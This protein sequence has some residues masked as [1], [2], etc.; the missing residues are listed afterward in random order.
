MNDPN[1][2]TRWKGLYHLFY[3]HNPYSAEWGQIHWGHAVSD[4][5]VHWRDLPIA[6][7]PNPKGPDYAGCWSGC[8]V[9]H[10]DV[11]MFFYT[12]VYPEAVCI[13]IGKDD[14]LT[15]DKYDGNPVIPAPPEGIYA[16]DP[17][18]FRDPFVWQ[19]DDEWYMLIASRQEGS[20]G[21]ALLYRSLDLHQWEYLHPFFE[22][23][24]QQTQ[25]FWMG[26]QW[27]C[28]NY[29]AQEDR[30]VLIVSVAGEGDGDLRYPAYFVGDL[31]DHRLRPRQSGIVDYGSCFY[32][33]Q[34]LHDKDRYLMWGWLQE[35]RS[36]VAQ[37]AAGWSGVMSLPR[38]ISLQDDDSLSIT[39]APELQQLRSNG[40]SLNN[41]SLEESEHHIISEIEGD[42]LEIVASFRISGAARFGIQVRCSPDGEERTTIAFGV[43]KS[44]L[45]VDCTQSSLDED[46]QRDIC[47]AH[48]PLPDDSLLTLHVFLDRS[49]LE[50]F[51][52]DSTVISTRIYPTRP[53]SMGLQLFCHEGNVQV[54]R[55][56]IWKLKSIW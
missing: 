42:G 36:T 16:G 27:E 18:D 30:H 8:A 10:D 14:L 15:L 21:M 19:N 24:M 3:Q 45:V 31:E 13:A 20:G 55:C 44:E 23:D 25:P 9:V 32:A 7:S 49:V 50:V 33:P 6:L 40:Q 34:I 37:K 43:Q 5:L 12:G 39:P 26:V 41:L 28:P 56:D 46:T 22:G 11:T 17:W 51:A 29:F 53:D 47:S 52:N 38:I 48:V 35:T 4:D 54:E 1:G 2:L